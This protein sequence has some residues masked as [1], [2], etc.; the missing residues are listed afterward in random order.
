[1]S[2]LPFPYGFLPFP[3]GLL[4]SAFPLWPAAFCL[5][6]WPSALPYR[7]L[8]DATINQSIYLMSWGATKILFGRHTQHVSEI[9]V[10]TWQGRCCSV[11]VMLSSQL[12]KCI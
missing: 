1:M 8:L 5:P 12:M 6:L 7:L 3:Y 10:D 4:P 11:V 2:P 9:L